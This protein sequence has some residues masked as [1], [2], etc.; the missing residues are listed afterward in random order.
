MT[1]KPTVWV[2]ALCV[3]AT[4]ARGQEPSAVQD[5]PAA[6]QPAALEDMSVPELL[7]AANQ[8]IVA[9]Q[10]AR[11]EEAL[12]RVLQRDS[13]NIEALFMLGE[14]AEAI[15]N[16]SGART[17]YLRVLKIE[18]NHFGANF[19]LGRAWSGNRVWR[20]AAQ[21]LRTAERVAPP[22]RIADVQAFLASALRGMHQWPE[23]L[24]VVQKAVKT[25]PENIIARQTLAGIH[26]D[27]GNFE[28]ALA[29]AEV[30]VAISAKQMAESPGRLDAL[31]SMDAAFTL[32]IS[33]LTVFV[34]SFYQIN[35]TGQRVD[36]LVP[37][38]E[39]NAAAVLDG[40]RKTLEAQAELQL[41]MRYHEALPAALRATTYA[42]D[43]VDYLLALGLLY[44]KTYQI[45]EAITTFRL[46]LAID[47]DHAA[48]REQLQQMR[49][50]LTSQPVGPG[51]AG[52]ERGTTPGG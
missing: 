41:R 42:P 47:P 12:Q 13:T 49:A 8:A 17:I 9:R 36:V 19:G 26:M 51:S 46:I 31:Q 38:A 7:E 22:D 4:G 1:W 24:A 43:N 18:K 11:T 16:I 10:F 27:M 32:R 15:G 20:Q 6:S 48:A 40:F 33:A 52:G 25:A 23:A 34:Q 39:R 30:L 37:G 2:V 44:Q 14:T 29:A 45:E 21:Y 28:G 35:E 5:P 50:P 3:L